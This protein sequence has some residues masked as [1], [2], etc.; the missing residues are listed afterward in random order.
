[1]DAY[2]RVQDGELALDVDAIVE[3]LMNG[4]SADARAFVGEPPAS[5]SRC[6]VERARFAAQFQRH[7]AQ[8]LAAFERFRPSADTYSPLNFFFNF[9]HNI[10]KGTV[11]DALL[12]GEPWRVALNDLLESGDRGGPPEAAKHA[13][14]TTLMAYARSHPDT[15]RG[16][17]MP[18]IVYD[19]SAGRRA[20]TTAMQKLAG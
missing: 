9:S 1:M 5:L 12:R 17:L 7:R 2:A 6:E 14:A 4:L 16:R 15:I 20:F 11:V 18:V 10:V 19:P 3:P 8:L 13:L